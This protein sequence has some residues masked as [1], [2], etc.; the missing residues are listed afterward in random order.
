MIIAMIAMWM[1][2]M[3]IHEIIN[4][5]PVGYGLVAA[6]RTMH[7]VSIVA[8]A[9]MFRCAAIRISSAYL[10]HVLINMVAMRVMQMAIVKV[11]HMIAVTNGGV[12]AIRFML[13]I[14]IVVMRKSAVAHNSFLSKKLGG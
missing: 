2:Q 13:V 4:M 1:M 12:A 11:V 3:P 8:R 14:M 9:M 5:I 7:M 10:K 6:A